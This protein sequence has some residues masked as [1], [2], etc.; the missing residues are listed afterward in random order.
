MAN[1]DAQ[2]AENFRK[3]YEGAA[4]EFGGEVANELNIFLNEEDLVVSREMQNSIEWRALRGGDGAFTILVGPT[5]EYAEYV[6]EGTAPHFP[7]DGVL[8]DWIVERGF[9]ADAGSLDER[10]D[11]LQWHIYQHGTEANPFM[12]R[13]EQD[14]GDDFAKQYGQILQKRIELGD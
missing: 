6:H 7:P 3:A 13:F 8:R 9:A 14:K 2:N 11:L 10:E 1:E 4:M 5:I 12:D